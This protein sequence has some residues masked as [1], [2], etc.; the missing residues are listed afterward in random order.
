[1]LRKVVVY[2]E[3]FVD[4]YKAQEDKVREKIVY[5]LDLVRFEK[6][7]PK[8]SLNISKTQTEFMKCAWLPHLKT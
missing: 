6:K 4:F 7:V 1:M 2:N 3:Y 5:V 8:N